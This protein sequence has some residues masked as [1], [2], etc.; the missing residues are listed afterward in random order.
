MSVI[1]CCSHLRKRLYHGGITSAASW[2][3]FWMLEKTVEDGAAIGK[4][5]VK[6]KK[7]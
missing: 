6:T 3:H 1:L 4:Q 7:T 2:A 5:S